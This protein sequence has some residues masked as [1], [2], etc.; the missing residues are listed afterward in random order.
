MRLLLFLVGTLLA[1][2][3]FAAPSAADRPRFNAWLEGQRIVSCYIAGDRKRIEAAL[4][5]DPI[6][7]AFEQWYGLRD[8]SCPERT[9]RPQAEFYRYALAEAL[10]RRDLKKLAAGNFAMVPRLAHARP[11]P[12]ASVGASKKDKDRAAGEQAFEINLSMLGECLV[13]GNPVGSHAV[14]S[15]EPASDAETAA[16]ASMMPAM[17]RCID[18]TKPARV[19]LDDVRGTIAVN[20]LRLAKAQPSGWQGASR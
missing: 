4:V 17:E 2:Q 9:V 12:K 3:A 1:S 11:A 19:G 8:K 15:S 10:F 14:L 6:S 5:A 7:G 18:Q 13:R 16:F 20:Y